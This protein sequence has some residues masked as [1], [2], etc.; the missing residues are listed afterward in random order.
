MSLD[1]KLN[2]A[3]EQKKKEKLYRV[4]QARQAEQTTSIQIDGKHYLNFC[5]N[6]YLGLANHPEIINAAKEG[7]DK[8]GLGSGGSALVTGYTAIHQRLE[9]ELAEFTER[10]RAL[11]YTSGFSANLGVCSTLLNKTDDVY[12]DKLCHASLIDGVRLSEAKIRRYAHLDH[13][14]LNTLLTKSTSDEKWVISESLFSMDGDLAPLSELAKECKASKANLYIDD[15]HGIGVYGACG[16]GYL[17]AK[18]LT[19]QQVPIMVA[20]FGKAFGAA[21][22]FVAGSEALIETLIQNSRSYIYTTAMPPS[23]AAA[24]L[25]SLSL[26]KKDNWRRDKLF[27]LVAYFRHAAAE[28]GIPLSENAH[29]PIQPVIIGDSEKTLRISKA[30]AEHGIK[31]TAIRAPTVAKNAARLRVTF[32]AAHDERQIDYLVSTLAT[33]F[34]N[35]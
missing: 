22:A 24:I 18:K 25:K 3:L 11:L 29:G 9:S 19:E 10:S 35:E 31:I 33:I 28:K 7:L 5:S 20:T 14:N 12:L 16:A 13:E 6:D 32:S 8:Y 17:N 34:D 2:K 26:I 21:G 27:N 23:N 30:L 4:L 1:A 15:A